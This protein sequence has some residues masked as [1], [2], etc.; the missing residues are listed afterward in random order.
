MRG[1][2]TKGLVVFRAMEIDFARWDLPALGAAWQAARPFP[3]VI[4]DGLVADD[5][6]HT[7]RAA[8]AEEPHWPNSNEIYE[9]MGSAQPMSHPTLRAFEATL[10]GHAA[11]EAV[12]A[13][14]GKP[15]GRI[16]MR[17]YVFMPG[18]YLL[19]HS[20]C[21]RAIGRLVAFAFYLWPGPC[22]GGE[23]EL[24]DCVVDGDAVVTSHPAGTIEPRANRLVLF[25]VSPAS[26]HQVREVR[27]GARLSLSGWF[28][29]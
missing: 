21:Q 24:F 29:T 9:M 10:G 20:D 6:L 19:P 28:Y 14:T 7:L 12:R 17:S 15:V 2:H 16:E 11:V 27:A 3:H 8:M 22:E 18:M 26:L 23:L 13:V 25:D 1:D 5:A 4:V